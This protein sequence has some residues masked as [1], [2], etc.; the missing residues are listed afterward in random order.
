MKKNDDF[1]ERRFELLLE[2]L[3]QH[4]SAQL[5]AIDQFR[6]SE[7]DASKRRKA[8]REMAQIKGP[9]GAAGTLRTRA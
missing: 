2:E 8:R 9:A 7:A 6:R 5:E 1:L 3:R 4:A